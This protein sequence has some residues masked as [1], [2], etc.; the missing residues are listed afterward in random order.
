MGISFGGLD[1]I[2]PSLLL[3]SLLAAVCA[4]ESINAPFFFFIRNISPLQDHR[5]TATLP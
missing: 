5:A 1:C 3:S 4:P 2:H